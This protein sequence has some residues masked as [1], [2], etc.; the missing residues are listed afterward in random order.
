MIYFDNAASGGFKPDCVKKA[1]LETLEYPANPGRSGHK[2]ASAAA[3]RISQARE[4]TADFFGLGESGTI[5]FTHNCTASL[6]YAIFG[7]IKCGHVITTAYEH[8]SVL[9]P[10]YHLHNAG[11]I[12][13]TVVYPDAYGLIRTEAIINAVR[14]NTKMIIVNH[15]SNVTGAKAPI[16]E[17]GAYTKKRGIVFLVD[18]AQSAGHV[19][20]NMKKTGINI[21]AAAGHKGLAAPQGVGILAVDKNIVLNPMIL[22]GT[23][24]RSESPIQPLDL[25][26]S[27]ESGTISTPAI[28]GLDAGITWIR[29]N[30]SSINKNIYKMTKHL[31]EEIKK[32]PKVIVYTP[33][34]EYNGLVTFNIEGLY[35]S[36]TANLLDEKFDICVRAGLHC[37]PLAHKYLGT[38]KHGAVRASLSYQNTM[39]EVEIFLKAIKEIVKN[40]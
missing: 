19:N 14:R 20:I 22:G 24:T 31:Y 8:N 39:D 33:K 9:R 34:G 1:V 28:A 40:I 26:E 17:I 30:F 38:I 18:A 23:G 5:V 37:A 3:L 13:F 16:E 27:L 4:N 11:K 32:I 12:S 36:E 29:Q 15:I 7:G 6:N 10:L 2:M 25:P 21:L 35:S